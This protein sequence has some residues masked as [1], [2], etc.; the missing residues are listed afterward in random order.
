MT[1]TA[2][3]LAYLRRAGF[4]LAA[5]VEAWIPHAS[6]RR[7]LFGIAD[8]LAV[9]PRDRLFLL[10]QVTTAGHVAHRLAKVRA[11]PELATWLRAGGRFEVHG[12]AQRGGRWCLPRGEVIGADL[13]DVVLSAPRPRRR[14]RGDR[15]AE[16]PFG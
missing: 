14:R 5:V 1:P 3:T 6:L 11:R 16:L 7:D 9:H 10:V 12:W 4:L 13:S 2:R 15:Q 8:V